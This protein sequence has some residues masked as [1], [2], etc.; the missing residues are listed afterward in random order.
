M[1]KEKEFFKIPWP[2]V[3]RAARGPVLQHTAGLIG[4]STEPSVA[5]Q[6]PTAMGLAHRARDPRAAVHAYRT[7]PTLR[8]RAWGWGGVALRWRP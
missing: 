3:K 6:Q 1:E 8:A 4:S 5:C 7:T 2:R